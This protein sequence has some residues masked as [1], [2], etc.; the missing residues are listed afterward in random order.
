MIGAMSEISHL[1]VGVNMVGG[2]EAAVTRMVL[3][4]RSHLVVGVN[5]VGDCDAAVLRL[6]QSQRSLI[7]VLG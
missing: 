6:V 3:C 4:Q 7:W 2:C 5:M 1:G